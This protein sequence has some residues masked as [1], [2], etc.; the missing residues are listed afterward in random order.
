MLNQFYDKFIFTNGLKY[1]HNN[2]F[3][4]NLPFVIAPNEIFTGLLEVEDE[5]FEKKLYY[6]VKDVVRKHLIKEFGLDFGYTGEK[7]VKFLETYFVASGWGAI[8]TVNLDFQNKR[9]IVKVGNNPFTSHLHKKI[10]HPCDHVLRGIFAGVFGKVFESDIDC[11]EVHC[12]ALGEQDCEF[13]VKQQHDFDLSNK[14]V[15]NQLNL[16]I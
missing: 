13:I 11:V 4:L 3:L 6:A 12:S 16:S 15:L 10:A 8:K 2:F 5:E 1:K 7:L 9:A 14:H